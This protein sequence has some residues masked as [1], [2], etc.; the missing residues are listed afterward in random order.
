MAHHER[1]A[2][3]AGDQVRHRE[4]LA[5]ARDA[6]QRLVMVAGGAGAGEL[7]DRLRLVARRGVIVGQ[8]EWHGGW[9]AGGK[10]KTL[11][12]LAGAWAVEACK[13]V[14]QDAEHSRQDA[15]APPWKTATYPSCAR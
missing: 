10:W 3:C 1:G 12:L 6:K 9:G 15:G 2:S 14:R 8:S 13:S 11:G 7:F 4:R 5:R